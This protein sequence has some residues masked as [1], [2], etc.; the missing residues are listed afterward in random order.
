MKNQLLNTILTGTA[1]TLASS[2]LSSTPAQAQATAFVCGQSNNVP[3]TMAQTPRGNV[4]VI[5]WNSDYFAAAGYDPQTRC[6]MVSQRFQTFLQKKALNYITT[7]LINGQKVVCVAR[8]QGGDCAR[9]L[10]EAG[11][12]FTLKPESN[13]GQTLRQLMQVRVG[14]SGPLNENDA[15]V[16]INVNDF[17]NTSPVEENT[18][19]PPV[20]KSLF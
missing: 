15:R 14:A 18:M 12:L 7:G 2:L 5:R 19:N 8:F 16:Y 3:A 6:E 11:L 9:D 10:P 17:L 1:I 20:E 13:P 4:P